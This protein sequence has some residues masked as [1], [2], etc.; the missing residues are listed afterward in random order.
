MVGATEFES[1]AS[2]S[3]T[4]H[5]SK[6]SYAPK[7]QGKICLFLLSLKQNYYTFAILFAVFAFVKIR[8]KLSDNIF[9]TYFKC[10]GI[11]TLMQ[12]TSLPSH[13]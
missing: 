3:Q 12:P 2:R 6:L 4:A 13:T 5:S 11:F 8:Y 9:Q 10:G 1:A 7:K